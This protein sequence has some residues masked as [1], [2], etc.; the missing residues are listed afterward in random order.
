MRQSKGTLLICVLPAFVYVV[1]V[2]F[3]PLFLALRMSFSE[4]IGG[5]NVFVGLSHYT[6]LLYDKVFWQITAQTFYF[7]GFSV[8][9]HFSI[10][11]L[12]ALL[13]NQRIKYRDLWRGLQAIPWLFP[14][15]VTGCIWIFIFQ[16]QY[17]LLNSILF[18]LNLSHLA[19]DWLGQT[20]LALTSVTIANSWT[21]FSF[22]TLMFLAAMQNIPRE[23]Y[24]AAAIDGAGSW[25][26]FWYVTLPNL[27]PIMFTL[28]LLDFIWTFR[29]FDLTWIM[30]KGGPVRSSEILPTYVYKTAFH[31]FDYHRAA[32]IGA[33]MMIFLLPFTLWYLKLYRS[34]LE[35]GA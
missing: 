29:F 25:S 18:R 5:E 33:A 19:Q 16:P 3:V 1:I 8:L 24:E 11:L 6:R 30:T 34:S 26:R 13:L 21:F 28:C 9:L 20:N 4:Q 35:R 22:F 32:A 15:A 17:G 27:K 10:G 23:A 2:C 14:A 31:N 12:F 7:A